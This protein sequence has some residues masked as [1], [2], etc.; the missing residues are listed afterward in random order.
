[1]KLWN[2]KLQ[3]QVIDIKNMIFKIS[4][5]RKIMKYANA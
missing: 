1:M 2:V 5:L 3:K 4:K